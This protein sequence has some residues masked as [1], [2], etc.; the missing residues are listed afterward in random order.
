MS[1]SKNTRMGSLGKLSDFGTTKPAAASS[2]E[3]LMKTDGVPNAQKK[4][5]GTAKKTK[6]QPSETLT[7]VNIKIKRDQ[8]QWLSDTA[9]QVRDNNFEPVRPSERMYPQHLIGVAIE[10]LK[11][12]DLKWGDIKTVGDL[13]DQLNL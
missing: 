8:H 3:V 12:Q 10:L 4:R 7:T 6:T 13:K 1:R 9:R 2:Q 5:S 11:N